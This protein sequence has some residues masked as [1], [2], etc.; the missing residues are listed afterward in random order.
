MEQSLVFGRFCLPVLHGF[1][2]VFILPHFC[3]STTVHSA[4]FNSVSV[5]VGGTLKD[6][7]LCSILMKPLIYHA[8][9]NIIFGT[10]MGLDQLKKHILNA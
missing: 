8:L 7:L 9:E 3:V 10:K 6:P 5:L 2:H 4:F 1:V